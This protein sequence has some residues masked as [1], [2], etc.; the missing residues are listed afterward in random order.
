MCSF[1]S[2]P[3]THPQSPLPEPLQNAFDASGPGTAETPVLFDRI[4]EAAFDEPE[5]MRQIMEM[6]LREIP[7]EL[8]ALMAAV[9]SGNLDRVA[10][11]AHKSCGTCAQS[12]LVGV[13][14]PLQRIEVQAKAGDAEGLGALVK[15]VAHE[16]E[17]CRATLEKRVRELE[18]SA[19]P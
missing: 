18:R 9:A 14:P 12:G 4:A 8:A 6:L 5:R 13:V 7:R 10:R 15:T 3:P 17:R 11:A 16:F 1:E 19:R 2:P